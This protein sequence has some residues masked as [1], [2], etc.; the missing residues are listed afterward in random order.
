MYMIRNGQFKN[1]VKGVVMGQISF[2][3][4]VYWPLVR[5]IGVDAKYRTI[6]KG[7]LSLFL[8][9]AT[10]LSLQYNL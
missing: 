1:V 5:K 10:E 3:N 6:K 8:F 7:V 2:I 4:E 9:F